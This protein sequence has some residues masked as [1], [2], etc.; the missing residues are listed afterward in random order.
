MQ[1]SRTLFVVLAVA[2]CETTPAGAQLMFA[3]SPSVQK[4]LKLTEDQVGKVKELDAKAR[5]D[6][7]GLFR[8]NQEEER[9]QR[10]RELFK[11]TEKALADILTP[12]QSKRLKQ[13]AL[14]ITGP[15][16]VLHRRDSTN[17]AS[18][19]EVDRAIG[20]T[21]E[22]REKISTIWKD[23]QASA[24]DLLRAGVGGGNRVYATPESTK[25]ARALNS[26]ADIEVFAL[27]T[28]EQK[29]KW[30]ELIGEVFTGTIMTP[31]GPHT[32]QPPFTV[33]KKG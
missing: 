27:L 19:A 15:L 13:I 29:R 16:F 9:Q 8:I 2:A 31:L 26:K 5:A 30:K 32:P 14:Q 10:D 28:D 4:E 21:D 12:E 18:Q 6:R 3:Q 20:L 23:F 1:T 33:N 24:H 22:Q 17:N 11:A 25:K 7:K